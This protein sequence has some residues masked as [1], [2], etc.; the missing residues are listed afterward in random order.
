MPGG[1]RKVKKREDENRNWEKR[2]QIIK[3]RESVIRIPKLKPDL[4]KIDEVEV[5]SRLAERQKTHRF[6]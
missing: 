5:G 6:H 3:Q 4:L 1:M 2:F